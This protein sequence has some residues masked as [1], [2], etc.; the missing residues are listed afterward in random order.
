LRLRRRHLPLRRGRRLYGRRRVLRHLR[1]HVLDGRDDLPG[2]AAVFIR[3]VLQDE[4]GVPERSGLRSAVLRWRRQRASLRAAD[5]P[6]V[7]VRSELSRG[8]SNA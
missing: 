8:P 1:F 2:Q 7:S 5:E 4:R 6:C 3:A